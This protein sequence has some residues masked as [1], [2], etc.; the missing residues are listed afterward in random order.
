MILFSVCVLF[1]G[2]VY[3][4]AALAMVQSKMTLKVL[5]AIELLSKQ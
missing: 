2:M 1:V 3:V 5:K 4:V